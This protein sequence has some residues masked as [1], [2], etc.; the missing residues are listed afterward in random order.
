VKPRRASLALACAALLAT[1]GAEECP[2]AF[3]DAPGDAMLDGDL[4]LAGT[5]ELLE[6]P[7]GTPGV[8]PGADGVVDRDDV[9]C[10][11]CFGDVDIVVRTGTTE[12][13]ASFPKASIQKGVAQ[14]PLAVAE[15]FGDGTPVTF[16]VG[17][18]D[19]RTPPAAGRPVA[20][21]SLEGAPVLAVAF[22]DLD[23]DGRIGVTLLDGDAT[24]VEIEEQEQ[25]PIGRRFALASGGRAPG[26]L[27]VAAGGPSGARLLVALGAAAYAGPFRAQHFGGRVPDGPM[28]MTQ[29]PFVPRTDPDAVIDGPAPGPASPDALT[30]AEVG[31]A[32]PPD[33]ARPVVLERFTLDPANPDASID[34][35]RAA[36]GA[37]AR[38][39]LAQVPSP[40]TYRAL[41][42]RPLRPGLDGA[43]ARRVYEIVEQMIVPDDGAASQAA[44]RV[45]PLDRLGNVADL[46]GSHA[47]AVRAGGGARIASSDGDDDAGGQ[48]STLS[49]ANARGA[50]LALDDASPAEF[51]DA[52]GFV[53]IESAEGLVRIEITFPDPDV[54]DDGFVDA[55]DA[56]LVASREDAEL[57]DPGYDPRFDLSGN[58]RIR[59]EDVDLVEDHLGKTIPIP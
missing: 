30:G 20:P 41:P 19:G 42:R 35:A 54:D 56:A 12:I 8:L 3:D 55:A 29:L 17:A 38:F 4:T 11:Y 51:D 45:V 14:L 24:D 40:A 59:G 7:A 34:F 43:G 37:F 27:F 49:I 25:E 1:T 58:G 5:G 53:E 16:V 6:V 44:T 39:G 22:A 23:G 9:V 52:D 48:S 57:G 47:V 15:P 10:S 33:P 2:V 50:A 31:V 36:S 21:P 13:G 28:V 32:F 46:A 26:G 18:S